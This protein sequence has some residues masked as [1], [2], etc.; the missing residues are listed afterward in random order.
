MVLPHRNE[1]DLDELPQ[2]VHEDMNF[3]LVENLAQVF[4]AC[5]KD[6]AVRKAA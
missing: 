5:F 4:S 2:E 6:E 3:I 1:K